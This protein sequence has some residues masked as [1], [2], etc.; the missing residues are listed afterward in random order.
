MLGLEQDAVEM[1]SWGSFCCVWGG[2]PGSAGELEGDGK[3]RIMLT[4][5]LEPDP[6]VIRR[7][8]QMSVDVEK[9]KFCSVHCVRFL[10]PP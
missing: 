6:T 8:G 3:G 7:Q 4:E 2:P 1:E 9:Q 10:R 5:I